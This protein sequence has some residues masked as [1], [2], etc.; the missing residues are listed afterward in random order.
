[1]SALIYGWDGDSLKES[2]SLEQDGLK[3]SIVV[4]TLNQ[5]VTIRDT[6]LSIIRQNYRNFEI[7]VMDGGSQDSTLEVIKEYRQYIAHFESGDDGGQSAAINK[8]FE[9]ASGDIFAWINSDDF[10]LPN[11]F[12]NIVN[13]FKK[14]NDVAIVVGSGHVVTWDCKFL[15]QIEGIEMSR[16][17]LLGWHNDKWI[18]QQSCFWTADIWKKSGGVDQDLQLLMDYDLWLRFAN[19]GKSIA[20]KNNIA[21]MRY[22][23]Q[24]KTISMKTKMS[25]EEA[26]V[27]AKN[28]AFPELKAL[29][30]RLKKENDDLLGE[31]KRND[32]R[33]ITRVSKRLGLFQ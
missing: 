9:F 33:L 31:V 4:P 8:G 15:K 16:E 28:H 32:N 1:M 22:Y 20:I 26:Y 18:M 2:A 23:E 6:L 27:Y 10:Y 3:L 17:N 13:T 14:C 21:V 25:E 19:L 29:V 11:A 12:A 5:G 30:R 7:I 24:T